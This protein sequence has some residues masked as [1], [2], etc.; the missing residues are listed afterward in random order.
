MCDHHQQEYKRVW[1][2]E[3]LKTLCAFANAQ[4]GTLVIGC[5]DWTIENLVGPHASHPGNPDIANAFFRAGLIE[6]WGRGMEQI[7]EACTAAENPKPRIVTEPGGLWLEFPFAIGQAPG[8]QI[9]GSISGAMGGQMGGA[10]ELTDRQHDLIGL[11][12]ADTR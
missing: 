7:F 9:G 6:A 12:R 8:G 3:W 10:I 1:K 2:D 5:D 4:G 11:I